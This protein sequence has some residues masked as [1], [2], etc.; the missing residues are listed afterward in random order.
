MNC[1]YLIMYSPLSM[2]Q[3]CAVGGSAHSHFELVGTPSIVTPAK[4]GDQ[5][6]GDILYGQNYLR[7]RDVVNRITRCYTC[8][9]LRAG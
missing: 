5:S 3:A 8:A 9:A 6:W 4:A 1:A 7:T 2:C